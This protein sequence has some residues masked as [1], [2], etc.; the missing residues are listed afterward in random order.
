MRA[1]KV[2]RR[3]W[4]DLVHDEPTF[5]VGRID[6]WFALRPGRNDLRIGRA[7]AHTQLLSG[8]FFGDGAPEPSL[9]PACCGRSVPEAGPISFSASFSPSEPRPHATRPSPGR[10][11]LVWNGVVSRSDELCASRHE[12]G[13]R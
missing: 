5:R 7:C 11:R 3:I 13:F 4:L 9:D 1:H 2:K 8:R 10:V 12:T 6:G